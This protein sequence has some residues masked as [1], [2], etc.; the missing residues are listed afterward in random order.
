MRE[1]WIVDHPETWWERLIRFALIALSTIPGAIWTLGPARWHASQSY[2]YLNELH[3]PWPA[4][5]LIFLLQAFLIAAPFKLRLA[6]YILGFVT[7]GYFGLM[8]FAAAV[9]GYVSSP[10]GFSALLGYSAIHLAGTRDY[11][12]R[13]AEQKVRENGI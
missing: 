10:L 12:F 6:G 5:G 1:R 4:W 11:I 13:N 7:T 9:T 2:V 8:L 3:M